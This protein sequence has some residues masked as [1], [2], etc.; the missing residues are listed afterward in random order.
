[1]T[2]SMEQYVTLGLGRE[3]FAVPVQAVRE[4]LDM[5]PMTAI[6][7]APAYFGG[8]IDVR[9]ESIPVID[10]RRKLGLPEVAVTESSRIL[11]TAVAGAGRELVLGLVADRVIEVIALEAAAVEAA[12][13]IGVRWRS[14]YIRGIGRNSQGFVI[15]LDLAR[16]FAT[17]QQMFIGTEAA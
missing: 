4:I 9:N 14:D 12:P 17:E 15:I 10:L 7:E 6:P 8:L 1:M 3:V 13:D 2:Q 16:L 11:V 5:R